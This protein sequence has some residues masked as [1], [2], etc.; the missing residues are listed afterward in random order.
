MSEKS[1]KEAISG[2]A[3]KLEMSNATDSKLQHQ[4]V[5]VCE[6]D[7]EN[8]DEEW[9]HHHGDGLG[10]HALDVPASLHRAHHNGTKSDLI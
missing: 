10:H 3:D 4:Y 9:D 7:L 5:P 6:R 1:A 2:D 8:V